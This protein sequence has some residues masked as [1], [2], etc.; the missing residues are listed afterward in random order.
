MP[1]SA[2][3][4]YKFIRNLLLG[5]HCARHLASEVVLVLT[6]PPSKAG[7]V[8]NASLIPGSARSPGEGHGNPLQYSRIPWTEKP[9]GLQAHRVVKSQ[10]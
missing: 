4:I 1:N 5:R 9:G 6:N 10:T 3:I 2:I 7:D 8:R